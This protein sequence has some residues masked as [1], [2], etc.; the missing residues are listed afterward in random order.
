MLG[1]LVVNTT[2]TIPTVYYKFDWLLLHNILVISL[3]GESSVL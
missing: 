2:L 1:W 3:V